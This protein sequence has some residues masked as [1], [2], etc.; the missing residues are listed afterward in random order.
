M[1]SL[2]LG[3]LLITL[4]FGQSVQ[5]SKYWVRNETKRE[6][7]ITFTQYIPG[8][9]NVGR[10]FA[11]LGEI[12][13]VGS[14]VTGIG[15]IGAV[16]ALEDLHNLPNRY[17]DKS[18]MTN[19]IMLTIPAEQSS[20]PIENWDWYVTKITFNGKE[21]GP[22]SFKTKPSGFYKF[23]KPNGYSYSMET[24]NSA[25]YLWKDNAAVI[26]WDHTNGFKIVDIA[27]VADSVLMPDFIDPNDYKDY[28]DKNK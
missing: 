18:E 22:G 16:Y 26:G 20:R 19:D 21:Y 15:I 4:I 14:M 3:F 9:F 17:P 1:K 6:Q 11:Y 8:K 27:G 24:G 13:A 25:P 23:N 10:I 2:K 5:A 12:I 7:K 28:Y